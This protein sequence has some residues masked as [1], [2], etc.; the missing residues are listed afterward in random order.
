MIYKDGDKNFY[1]LKRFAVSGVTRDKVY[2]LSSAKKQSIVSY[3]SANPNGEAEI[4]S[5][6][7]RQS[8]KLKKFKWDVNF[9]DYII[10]GR[11]SRGNIVTKH[12]VNKIELK[13]KGVSTLK[14]RKIWFDDSIQRLNVDGRGELLGEFSGEDKLLIIRQNGMLKTISPEITTRFTD[15]MIVLEKWLPKKPIS[16]VYFD[17]KKEKYF[18]KRFLIENENKEETFISLNKNTFL[19][20]VCTDWK[21]VIELVYNK[22]RNK[23]QRSNTSIDIEEFISIKGIKAQGNQLTGYKVKQINILESKEY[24]PPIEVSANEIEV[25][26]ENEIIEEVKDSSENDTD[27]GQTTLF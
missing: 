12:S 24:V 26:D 18:L 10:K 5:V 8:T 22:E 14:P 1:Y 17:G 27:S 25:I 13:E 7:L 20:I 15:D 3:F 19:E 23:E 21:P 6:I 4:V 2:N 9:S 16:A 11:S